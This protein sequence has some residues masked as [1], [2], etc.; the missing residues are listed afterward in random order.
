M[1]NHLGF[2]ANRELISLFL[3]AEKVVMKI[4]ISLSRGLMC[5]SLSQGLRSDFGVGRYA[6]S[7]GWG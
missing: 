1:S 5:F 7:E 2:H 6:D 3:P 4:T